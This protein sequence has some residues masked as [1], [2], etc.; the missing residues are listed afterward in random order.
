M[1]FVVLATL[2]RGFLVGDLCTFSAGDVSAV[3]DNSMSIDNNSTS[4]SSSTSLDS[5]KLR[6][7]HKMKIASLNC[8]A[9]NIQSKTKLLLGISLCFLYL[10][11]N[12]DKRCHS[13][14]GCISIATS[15]RKA[16]VDAGALDR[17]Y[18]IGLPQNLLQAAAF[19]QFLVLVM[20]YL[21]VHGGVCH[22]MDIYPLSAA[23]E[24]E[25]SRLEKMTKMT[26]AIVRLAS[27]S[28]SGRAAAAFLLATSRLFWTILLAC[29][30]VP[31]GIISS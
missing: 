30:V 15:L 17:Q 26:S 25:I 19:E 9:V 20:L 18:P 23:D 4:P 16:A 5:M 6:L 1:L 27:S 31:L 28:T 3:M 22:M 10:T 13:H 7:T 24:L 2:G 29:L 21:G 11:S 12:A 8:M 14:R